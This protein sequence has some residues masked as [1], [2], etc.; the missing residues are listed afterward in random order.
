MNIPRATLLLWIEMLVLLGGL[1]LL[2]LYFKSRMLMISLLWGGTLIIYWWLRYHQGR[3]FMD[4]W[5]W[6]GFKD[7]IK[8]VLIRFV[9]IMPLLFG[10]MYW[11]LPE[12]LFSFPLERPD[13]WLMVMILY[14][15]LSVVPQE[16][17]YKTLFFGRYGSLFGTRTGPLIASALMFGY[18]HVMLGNIVAVVGTTLVGFLIGQS[19]LKSRSLA[20]ASFE[21]ALY[22]CWVYTLGLGIYFYT[23]A[24]WGQQ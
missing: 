8:P 15:V 4:E 14:P 7:N 5:N 13:R 22:G 20:L 9:L 2:V 21:H 19:Y 1:P 11:V 17:I 23:G 12:R 24:A 6:Q 3:R 10:F 16:M 18:M